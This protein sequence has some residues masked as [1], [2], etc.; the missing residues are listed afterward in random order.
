MILMAFDGMFNTETQDVKP[1]KLPT[2]A[3]FVKR[4]KQ[5]KRNTTQPVDIIWLP[6]KFENFTLQT[7][8]CRVIIA[9][10]H[11]LFGHIKA[12]NNAGNESTEIP[13]ALEITD[14]NKAS[15]MLVPI[16]RVGSWTELGSTG[17]RWHTP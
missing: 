16:E 17:L 13:F 9:P 3:Q 8:L 15:Y 1:E 10:K 11:P 4:V 12:F 2:I 5:T 14:W 6:G 7:E